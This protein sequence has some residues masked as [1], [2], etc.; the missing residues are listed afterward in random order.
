MAQSPELLDLKPVVLANDEYDDDMT[1][2]K[3]VASAE[4]AVNNNSPFVNVSNC[5]SVKVTSD[6][7]DDIYRE[8][9]SS[10]TQ[11]SMI[12]GAQRVTDNHDPLS[13][14]SLLSLVRSLPKEMFITEVLKS[15][16]SDRDHLD[17]ARTE[18][19]SYIQNSEGYPYDSR[20]SLKRRIKT[21]T[22]DSIE[23]KLA[24]DLHCLSTVLDG[25][26]WEDL[27][28]VVS[29]PRMSKKH[30]SSQADVDASFQAYNITDMENMKQT[31][32]GM[33]A[34]ILLL[35]QENTTLKSELQSEIKSVRAAI[36]SVN[37]DIET[38]L[39][40]LR[41]LIS[42]NALSIDRVCDEKSNGV[43][44]MRGEIKQ[45]KSDVKSIMEDPVLTLN[46]V[47]VKDSVAKLSSLEKRL[48]RLDKRLHNDKAPVSVDLTKLDSVDETGKMDIESYST[49][50]VNKHN[51]TVLLKSNDSNLFSRLPTK[52]PSVESKELKQQAVMSIPT[53]SSDGGINCEVSQKTSS[54]YVER[55]NAPSSGTPTDMRGP[56]Q[57][58]T[59]SS[60]IQG[61]DQQRLT[62]ANTVSKGTA[63]ATT[64][65]DPSRGDA[66]G[67]E[68][69]SVRL[70]RLAFSDAAKLNS[71]G[72]LMP[73]D[74]AAPTSPPKYIPTR[75]NGTLVDPPS[76]TSESQ[77]ERPSNREQDFVSLLG[78]VELADHV[79]KRT[80]RFYVG[81]F[82]SSITQ[83]ELI[84][85]VE[86]KGLLVT[87]VNIWNS[88]RY[89]R[90]VIRLNIE[91][92]ENYLKITEPGFWPRG[93]KCRPWLS[94]NTYKHKVVNNG[95]SMRYEGFNEDYQKD[96]DVSQQHAGA[97]N[98]HSYGYQAH[99]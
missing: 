37:S 27:K 22:G 75:V 14:D 15:S 98:H 80:K 20:S 47:Q 57:A 89:G 67:N 48:N 70:K 32:S 59:E 85:F 34:D 25:A 50:H 5:K 13:I 65:T 64:S 30:S 23:Y 2:L 93:I 45:I 79:R 1:H 39:N 90:V 97:D 62:Y 66:H 17:N 26:A 86:S 87:W 74:N 88:K 49:V 82:K 16:S 60:H 92:T 94:S 44:S 36:R 96:N 46:V 99:A 95:R 43:V 41:S 55:S 76:I 58:R 71:L 6:N 9:D 72:K 69:I 73:V 35:K 53:K 61:R 12:Q 24:Q 19:F 18:L 42:T 10:G 3:E 31:I 51:R 54:T 33:M 38:E 77:S 91:A 11:C 28:E 8:I 78:H 7:V 40:E 56:E 68:D 84:E 81:G 52:P 4:F 29:I 21:R 63:K 83:E